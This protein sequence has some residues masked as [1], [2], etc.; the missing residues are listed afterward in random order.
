[1]NVP[2]LNQTLLTLERNLPKDDPGWKNAKYRLDDGSEATL[3]EV[4][5]RA[6]RAL[7]GV[8]DPR[9]AKL[10]SLQRLWVRQAHEL[11]TRILRENKKSTF[12]NIFRNGYRTMSQRLRKM[13][14]AQ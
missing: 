11:L 14:R 1:M 10:T 5:A 6:R 4:L 3:P 13:W 2:E 7:T 8:S 12:D 9:R